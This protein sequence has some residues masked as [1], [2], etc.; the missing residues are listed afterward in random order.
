MGATRTEK[1]KK[2]LNLFK[3][4]KRKLS[5]KQAYSCLYY[6]KK[7]KPIVNE[8]WK[9]HI[10]EHPDQ[11][12]NRGDFLLHYNRVIKALYAAETDDVKAEVERRNEEGSLSDDE[13]IEL[14]DDDDNAIGITEQ[15]RWKRNQGF[16]KH[17]ILF[18]F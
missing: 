14:N 8:S 11:E 6:D 4:Q 2:P 5:P 18:I 7:L 3:R 17:V 16:H 10:A 15:R 12:G 1:Q 13:Y 9:Q